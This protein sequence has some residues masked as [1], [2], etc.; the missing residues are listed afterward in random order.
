M[1]QLTTQE[2][3]KQS[4][5]GTK[6]I[7]IRSVDAYNGWQLSNE[8]R[9]GPIKG[10]KSFPAKWLN[11]MDWIEM[12]HHKNILPDDQLLIYG[13]TKAESDKIANSFIKAGFN[14]VSVYYHFVD[15]W[16][17]NPDLPMQKLKRYKNLV[18]A[19]WVNELIK[20]ENPAHYQNNKF[21]VV[22]A[23][24][25]NRDAYLSGHIPS[26]I[27]MD[28]LAL[29]APETWNRRSP[30]ELKQ[31]LEMH[32]ISADTTVILYGKYMDPDNADEFPGSAAGDIGAIRNAF[33]MLYAGVKDVRVLNGGFQSWKDEGY[34]ISYADEPKQ[35]VAEFGQQIPVHPE[36]AVDTPEAKLI[37]AS[38]KAELVCVRSYPEY[39]G[40][41]SGYNYIEAKGRIPG[42]VFADCGSDAYHMENYRNFDHTTREYHEIA[43]IWNA[44]GISSDKHL[45]FYCG[46][47]WRGSEAW[48]NAWLMG[49]PN[50]SVY[51]G[52]WFE[53]SADPKNPFET[54]VPKIK[55]FTNQK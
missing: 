38:T 28:T 15:E 35:A 16:S 37:L 19:K 9:G 33:I 48:F 7:D 42:A 27:D 36:L 10:A 53:W 24:Y 43:E 50:V 31:A 5:N 2:L 39:I 34:E 55:S 3:L 51:D 4:Y 54:G 41:V 13:Y 44:N 8:V 40:K 29:E 6:I 12:V 45:A 52:G 47:G 49:W 30:E 26:A 1:N 14:N 32:G 46:T 22:H 25:R 20:G 18:S 11:Y 23:H 21:V 17:A